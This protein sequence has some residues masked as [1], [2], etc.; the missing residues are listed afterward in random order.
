M[1]GAYVAGLDA[2][3]AYNSWPKMGDEWFPS[4]APMMRPWLANLVDN[5]IVVQFIHRWLAWGVALAA[6]L[7]AGA[8]WTRGRRGHAIAVVMAVASRSRSESPP[9]SR[10]SVF[11]SPRPTRAW[12]SSSS[13]RS[14]RPRT[15]LGGAKGMS[16]IVTVY[17]T[18]ADGEE[19]GRIARRW[20]RSGSPPAPTSSAPAARSTAGRGRS[21]KRGDRRSVQDD[22]R[23]GGPPDR[24]PGRAA[25]L[26]RSGG[27]RLADRGGFLAGLWSVGGC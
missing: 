21:R 8:A 27:G 3:F 4:A 22:G 24:P 23:G 15:G 26:R 13:P 17:A 12:R 10:A 19:A 2:G 11:R 18:F 20:S 9:C 14:S 5:P 16:G 25:Q 6:A 7:L 1:Y